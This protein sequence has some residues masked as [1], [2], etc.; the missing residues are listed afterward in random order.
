MTIQI[1]TKEKY[2]QPEVVSCWQNLSKQGLQKCEREI[3]M[4]YFPPAGYLLDV[5]CGAGRAVLALDQAGYTVSG[6][7]LSLSMRIYSVCHLPTAP[8]KPSSCSLVLY[9]ISLVE[10]IAAGLWPRWPEWSSLMA[11]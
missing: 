6:I 10:P 2:N 3:V 9:S 1:S 11:V 8:L 4:R 5:G 7:D